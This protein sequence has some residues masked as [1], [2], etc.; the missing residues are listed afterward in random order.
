MPN[1][2]L[3][4]ALREAYAS[5]S[6]EPV[7]DTLEL[8]FPGALP[9]GVEF[10]ENWTYEERGT[11]NWQ[12][13]N[14]DG[15]AGGAP[16]FATRSYS[17]EQLQDG[18][19][20]APRWSL[21]NNNPLGLRWDYED[22]ENCSVGQTEAFSYWNPYTQTGF[23]RCK[24]RILSEQ[25]RRMLITWE[26][27][28][29]RQSSSYESMTFRYKKESAPSFTT[30]GTAHAPGGGLGCEGGMGPVVS[31][32]APPVFIDLEVGEVYDIEI[33]TSSND[34]LYH[35]GAY[36]QFTLAFFDTDTE[37]DELLD[38]PPFIEGIAGLPPV[39]LVRDRVSRDFTLEDGVTVRFEPCA[40]RLALPST[41][42]EG[43]QSI[44]V[45]IDNVD[46]RITKFL[47]MVKGIE[48]PVEMVY[49]PYLLSD[50]TK[51]QLNPPLRLTLTDIE[52]TAFEVTAA[53]R[54]ADVVN[55]RFLTQR[56]TR[57]RFRSLGI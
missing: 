26:G 35:N 40:F 12:G 44:R 53:A 23:A 14:A 37:T 1:E 39:Y 28:G 20:V 27:M 21:V 24:V 16:P 41:G 22:D 29:E 15:T 3:E 31:D 42:I 43:L 9:R 51:P 47:N 2:A 45:A 6:T 8:V 38:P 18:A 25:Y 19:V 5:A 55:S 17:I 10:V 32:P 7:L 52:V 11:I 33:Q 49:R 36:Y 46:Q 4:E 13:G 54:F 34:P 50:T 57:E 30:A 48:Y 56:Y